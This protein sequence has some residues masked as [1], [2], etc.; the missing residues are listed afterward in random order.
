MKILADA[1]N[2]SGKSTQSN[3]VLNHGVMSPYWGPTESGQAVYI[4]STQNKVSSQKALE[5][6]E[7]NRIL[8]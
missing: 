6:Q 5:N 4:L 8:Q 3:E 7:Q 1:L 2:I